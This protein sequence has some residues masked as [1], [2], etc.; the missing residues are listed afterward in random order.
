MEDLILSQGYDH[1]GNPEKWGYTQSEVD[2]IVEDATDYKKAVVDNEYIEEYYESVCGFLNDVGSIYWDGIGVAK[3]VPEA[4]WFYEKAI[5]LGGN[6]LA[7]CNLGDIYRKGDTG[8]TKNLD[9]A[10]E[11]YSSSNHPYA[12]Y[13]VGEA[14]EKGWGVNVDQGMAREYYRKSALLGHRLAIAKCK[15]LGINY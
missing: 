14:Y 10:F 5:E 8:V 1:K 7:G 4:I 2:D 9:K 3:D 15:E 12:I 11:A 13:R 6:D